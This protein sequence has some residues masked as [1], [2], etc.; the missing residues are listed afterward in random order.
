MKKLIIGAIVG[1]ILTFAW[2]TLSWTALELHRS[3]NDYTPKQDSILQFLNSQLTEDGSY[4]LPTYPMS[5]SSDE[6]AKIMEDNMGK[7]WVQ[8]SY[9]K[10]YDAN[11]G[12]NIIRGLL[13]SILMVALV[14]WI[15]Q[16][17]TS[18]SF[19]TIFLSCLAVGLVGYIHFPYSTYIWYRSADIRA[20]LLDAV[21]MW[22]LCGLW[23]GWWLR[24]S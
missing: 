23:L 5:A 14:I 7:P 17:M 18:P 24:R 16:K 15:L 3:A 12:M 22:G 9:H 11:M 13:T 19:Q 20:H 21:M 2:Q 1:G 10:A 8:L 6:K 4:F